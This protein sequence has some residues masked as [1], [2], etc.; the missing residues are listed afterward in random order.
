[1]NDSRM[2]GILLPDFAGTG[3]GADEEPPKDAAIADEVM[4][5]GWGL[6]GC[7]GACCCCCCCGAPVWKGC[8]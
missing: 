8:C 5:V 7:G 6:W 1:M 2:L 4:P 3:G